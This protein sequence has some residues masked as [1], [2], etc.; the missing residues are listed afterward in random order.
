MLKPIAIGRTKVY[1]RSCWKTKE[2]SQ[3]FSRMIAEKPET[4]ASCSNRR[5][6]SFKILERQ[7]HNSPQ[8]APVDLL[9]PLQEIRYQKVAL[10]QEAYEQLEISITVRR[11]V[12]MFD[13]KTDC[14][15]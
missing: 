11:Q 5:K 12:D 14:H 6:E 2:L 10:L 13:A 3:K 4:C 8:H 7:T 9:V 15:K 1:D